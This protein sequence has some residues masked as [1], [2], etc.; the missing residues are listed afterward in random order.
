MLVLLNPEATKVIVMAIK[1][2]FKQCNVMD[3]LTSTLFNSK[4]E[5]D[6]RSCIVYLGV[7]FSLLYF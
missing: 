3:S 6:F 5:V 4:I 1:I 2:L 7:L